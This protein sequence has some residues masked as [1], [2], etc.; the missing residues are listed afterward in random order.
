MRFHSSLKGFTLVEL[1]VVISIIGILSSIIVVGLSGARE[2]GR[3]S[4]RISDIR[5][6]QLALALYYEQNGGYPSA[7]SGLD[8]TFLD[9]VPT[10]PTGTGETSY[11]YVPLNSGCTSYHLGGTLERNN[12]SELSQDADYNSSSQTTGTSCPG[13]GSGTSGNRFNGSAATCGGSGSPDA[14]YDVRP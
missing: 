7:L 8:P 3:D 6:I 1:L 11:R 12:N 4:R 5:N 10:P 13:G 14:C 2:K 9:P